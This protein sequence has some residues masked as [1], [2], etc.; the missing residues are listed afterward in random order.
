MGVS[1]DCRHI[2]SHPIQECPSLMRM[3]PSLDVYLQRRGLPYH[4]YSR[5]SNRI[6]IVGHPRISRTVKLKRNID[7]V[8]IR[9]DANCIERNTLAGKSTGEKLCGALQVANQRRRTIGRRTAHL[10]LSTGLE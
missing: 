9:I 3:G 1:E 4:S 2:W 10:D 8:V 5:R 6:E 7:D